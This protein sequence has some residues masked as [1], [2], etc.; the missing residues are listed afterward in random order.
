MS[1]FRGA[2]DGGPTIP[3]QRKPGMKQRTVPIPE[4]GI[5]VT[6]WWFLA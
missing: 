3:V 2:C 4:P 5:P 6:Q 1:G